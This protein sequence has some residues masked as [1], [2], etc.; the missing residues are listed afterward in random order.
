[1]RM[2]IFSGLGTVI[3]GAL[4]ALLSFVFGTIM[5]EELIIYLGVGLIAGF[6]LGI[7][8]HLLTHKPGLDLSSSTATPSLGSNFGSFNSGI[9]GGFLMIVIAVVWFGLGLLADRIF[10]YPPILLLAGIV[11]IVRGLFQGPE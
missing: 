1:M 2:L 3:G 7:V 10:F 8:A 4:A 11:S 6:A 5:V 9:A